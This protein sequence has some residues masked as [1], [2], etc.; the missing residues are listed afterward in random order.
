MTIFKYFFK[1]MKEYKGIILLYTGIL[2]F[3]AGFNLSTGEN[4]ISFVAEKPDVLLIDNDNSKL[5][6]NLKEYINENANLKDLENEKDALFYRDV[7]LIIKIPKGYSN[8]IKENNKMD[9]EIKSTNDAEAEYGKMI[10]ERY[11]KISLIYENK[12]LTEDELI[13][14]INKSIRTTTKIN[15]SSKIDT[16]NMDKATFYYNFANYSILAGCVFVISTT[17]NSFKNENIKKRTIIS[18][19]NYKKYN[20]NLFLSGS[21]YGII[22]WL[23]YAL[24]SFILLKDVMFTINGILFLLNSFIFM[25]CSVSIAFF[26]GSLIKD[27]E[28]LNSIVNVIALGSSFLCGAFV[29]MN[30]LPDAVLKIA[31]FLPSYWFIKNNELI[32]TI[33]TISKN[34]IDEYLFNLIIIVVFIIIISIATNIISKK[35]RKIN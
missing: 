4:T 33:E 34:N 24:I 23:L 3:F 19:Y 2:I 8:S 26:M 13:E 35:N 12:N 27:K 10:L 17:L 20:K 5:S 29:P 9:I 28:A 15:I 31:H 32:K 18:S 30:F 21:T 16:K 6:N 7:S 22:L 11:L 1:V 25:L 14:K